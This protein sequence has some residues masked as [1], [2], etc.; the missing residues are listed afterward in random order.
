[1]KNYDDY[2]RH[3]IAARLVPQFVLDMNAEKKPL[4]GALL[5]LGGSIPLLILAWHQSKVTSGDQHTLNAMLDSGDATK[6]QIT[7]M[8]ARVHDSIRQTQMFLLA[9]ALWAFVIANANTYLVSAVSTDWLNHL[10]KVV[11]QV[12][13]GDLTKRVVRNNGSQIGD[14]Q[15]AIG[16][17]AVSFQKTIMRIE[18]A[19]VELKD[20]AGEMAHTSDE[21]GH[22]IGEV[23]HSVSEISEGASQQ[24]DLVTR[25][26]DVV[27]AI[28]ESVRTAASHANQAQQQSAET[29][30]LTEEGVLRATEVQEAMQTVRETSLATAEMIRSLG[31]KSTS[32]DQIIRSITDIASQTNLLALNAAIEAAR[33]G[34]QGRGFAVVAEEVRKLAEDAQASA[35]D[36]AELIGEIRDQTDQAVAAMENGVETV[37]SGFETVNRNRQIFFDISG[38]VSALNDSSEE[39]ATLAGGIAESASNVR[40]QISEVASVAEE[41]S[42]STE[43]VSASTEQTSAAA[44]EVTASAQRVAHTAV[45][46]TE[47][48]SRFKVREGE[49]PAQFKSSAGNKDGAVTVGNVTEIRE[50]AA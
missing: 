4:F 5:V 32:I 37:E 8:S 40:H 29:Q 49:A 46:L 26:A 10:A 18:D 45:R 33:A 7:A 23:A 3:R 11:N 21:A 34:E 28:E 13:D 41:S 43:E 9:A 20:A 12:A 47:M 39:I 2:T 25:T 24:V 31:D 22:A 27:G 1:V 17:M 6:A 42:A 14:I 38:A 36:I 16:K 19:A 48:A 35:G 15:E 44:Q 30:V 50:H